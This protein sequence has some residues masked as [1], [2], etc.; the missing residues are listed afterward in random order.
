MP[1][2]SSVE[3]IGLQSSHDDSYALSQV[4][5]EGQSVASGAPGLSSGMTLVPDS[6]PEE[7]QPGGSPELPTQLPLLPFA[8][9]QATHFSQV[10]P[11]T[12]PNGRLR[13]QVSCNLPGLDSLAG[14]FTSEAAADSWM[15]ELLA[16]HVQ[17]SSRYRHAWPIHECTTLVTLL[18][19]IAECF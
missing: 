4:P 11:T 8:S 6:Q 3:R 19:S 13:Y 2:H 17:S 12:L 16:Q 1:R 15:Q 10:S 7:A 18:G 14:T 9:Q 5:G